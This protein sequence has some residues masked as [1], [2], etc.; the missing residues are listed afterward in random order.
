[1]A[2]G[3]GPDGHFYLFLWQLQLIRESLDETKIAADAAKESADAAKI[4]AETA[5]TQAQTA[6]RTLQTMQ[7]TAE[8]QLRAYIFAEPGPLERANIFRYTVTFRNTGQTPAFDFSQTTNSDVFDH[9]ASEDKF[10]VKRQE[11]ISKTILPP[12][13]LVGTTI[14][15]TVSPEERGDIHTGS[16]AFYVFGDITYRDAFRQMRTVRFRFVH[17]KDCGPTDFGVLPNWER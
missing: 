15:H 8:R 12:G 13:R 17:S 9:P 4:Q 5:T 10:V 11:P 3:R 14:A 6:Q 7:D 1:M 16:K 2:E